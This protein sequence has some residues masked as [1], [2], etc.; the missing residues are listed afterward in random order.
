MLELS[1]DDDVFKFTHAGKVYEIPALTIDDVQSVA[2][3]V[4]LP[5]SQMTEKTRDYLLD[6]VDEETATIIRSIALK[7]YFRLFRAW[8]GMEMGESKPSDDS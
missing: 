4:A 6:R 2:E 7:S 8:A 3:F 1:A 5:H